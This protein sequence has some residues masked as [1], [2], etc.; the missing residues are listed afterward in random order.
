MGMRIARCV[1]PPA[2]Q[3]QAYCIPVVPHAVLTCFLLPPAQPEACLSV[4]FYLPKVNIIK[5]IPDYIAFISVAVPRESLHQNSILQKSSPVQNAKEV[6]HTP[7]A[8]VAAS[9][10]MVLQ[11][12]IEDHQERAISMMCTHLQI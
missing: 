8:V 11:Q 1:P 2:M 6:Q 7:V 3:C 12:H 9:G 10:G 4:N 5:H